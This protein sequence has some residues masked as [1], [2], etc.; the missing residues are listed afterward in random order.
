MS[1]DTLGRT[2]TPRPKAAVMGR[3]SPTG[4]E[5]WRDQAACR[6]ADPETFFHPE[7]ERGQAKANRI[8]AAKAVC[9]GCPSLISC[10]DQAREARE[11]HGIRGGESEDERRSW[12]RKQGKVRTAQRLI[13]EQGTA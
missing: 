5:P 6:D 11:Q 3:N 2:I 12:L 4:H 9:A 8:A 13:D 7:D 1:V 10:R